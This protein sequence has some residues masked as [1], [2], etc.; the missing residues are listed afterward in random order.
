MSITRRIIYINLAILVLPSLIFFLVAFFNPYQDMAI[1]FGVYLL[2]MP[3]VQ[4][5]VCLL[6][7]LIYHLSSRPEEPQSPRVK[8]Y[9]ISAG[10]VLLIGPSLCFGG[11]PFLNQM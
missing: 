6:C 3:V 4:G 2:V 7:A 9:L 8:G 11:M 5:F 10:L 1:Y